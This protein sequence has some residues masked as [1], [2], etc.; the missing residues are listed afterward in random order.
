MLSEKIKLEI[1][2][3]M[4]F[5]LQKP[6]VFNLSVYDNVAY[7]LKWR[8]LNHS[9]I[10]EKVNNILE[11][12]ELAKYGKRNA[13]TLSGGEMQR[14]AIARAIATG[15]EILLMDE[16]SANLDPKKSARIEDLIAAIIKQ[17]AITV[18]IARS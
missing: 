2:F 4:A 13:R 18:I 9:Q 6:V 5:V 14:V 12:V 3:R 16:P 10:R 8:G 11:T 1:R 15:P 17:N 7:G